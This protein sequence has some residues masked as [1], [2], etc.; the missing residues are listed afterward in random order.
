MSGGLISNSLAISLLS[1]KFMGYFLFTN[2]K[3]LGV[4]GEK[5]HSL[6]RHIF[7]AMAPYVVASEEFIIAPT[8][9][10]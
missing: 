9:F 3:E 6:T 10:S 5:R 2:I 8:D 4:E 1:T 7:F